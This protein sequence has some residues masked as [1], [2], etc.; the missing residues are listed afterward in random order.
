MVEMGVNTIRLQQFDMATDLHN[1]T[2][3]QYSDTISTFNGREAV[4]NDQSSPPLHQQVK[5]LLH[6]SF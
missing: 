4:R 6:R 5:R 1:T 3:F 2:V